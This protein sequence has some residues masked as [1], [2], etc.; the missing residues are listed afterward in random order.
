MAGPGLGAQAG[1]EATVVVVEV[2]GDEGEM[3]G[4]G[5]VQHGGG[6][7]VDV[8]GGGEDGRVEEVAVRALSVLWPGW[9]GRFGGGRSRSGQRG[10]AEF[11]G[12]AGGDGIEAGAVVVGV[13]TWIWALACVLVLAWVVVFV[14]IGGVVFGVGSVVIME[15]VVDLSHARSGIGSVNPAIDRMIAKGRLRGFET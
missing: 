3:E 8:R 11:I 10:R 12:E 6:G 5:A 7:G 13:I 4:V 1:L 2:E 15:G 9:R 14:L